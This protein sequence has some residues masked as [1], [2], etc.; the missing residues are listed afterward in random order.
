MA[1]CQLTFCGSRIAPTIVG[2]PMLTSGKPNF[3]PFAGDDEVAPC[4]HREPVPQ[5]VAV[6]SGDH[7]LVDLPTTFE[8]VDCRLLPER[9]GE[10][11]G[12][13]PAAHVAPGAE[14]P[15]RAG[16]D[17]HPCLLVVSEAAERIVESLSHLRVDGV[18]SVRPVVGDR[19]HM[20]RD[21]IGDKRAHPESMPQQPMPV[22][23]SSMKRDP[24][25]NPARRPGG[26]IAR[27]GSVLFA[28]RR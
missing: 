6:D 24:E 21:L 12:G 3:G 14:G 23:R 7:R 18:E 20:V 11:A 17:R 10:L 2:T 13:S 4:D 9:A 16:D 25:A 27:L 26:E 28:Q 15:P 1:Y 5:A 22:G 8:G 19:G